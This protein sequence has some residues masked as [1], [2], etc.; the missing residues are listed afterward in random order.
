MATKGPYTNI[1]V[2]SRAKYTILVYSF[3]IIP[4]K[5]IILPNNYNLIFKPK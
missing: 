1:L 5:P 4:I 3:I 2:I